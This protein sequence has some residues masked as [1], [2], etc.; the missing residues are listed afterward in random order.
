MRHTAYDSIRDREFRPKATLDDQAGNETEEEIRALEVPGRA[1]AD[2][3]D[4]ARS[5]GIGRM[6]V[7]MDLTIC[8]ERRTA[9]LFIF[10]RCAKD[11]FTGAVTG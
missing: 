4:G 6:I 5:H 10:K 2:G 1:K 8:A 3:R 7:L 11:E 9:M